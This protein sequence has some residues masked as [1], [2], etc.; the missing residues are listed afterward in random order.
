MPASA[1]EASGR[2]VLDTGIGVSLVTESLATA[3]GASSLGRSYSGRRMSGQEV[4]VPLVEL[5]ELR[6]GPVR[7]VGLVAGVLDLEGLGDLDGFLSLEFFR[8]APFTVDYA[9]SAV[10]V[11]TPESLEARASAGTAVALELVDEGCSLDAFTAL[12]L[13][14]GREISVEVDM[15]SDSLILD[16]SLAEP[17]GIDLAAEDVRRVEGVDETGNAY[18]RSFTRL[19]GAIHPAGAPELAQAEPEVMFQRIIHDGLVGSAF[20][21]R[22]A[23]TYDVAG[24]RMILAVVN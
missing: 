1:G 24:S 22:F 16:A 20:L 17:L 8:H 2:F 21:R 19:A 13:P 12:E 3:S 18:V 11:E 7:R 23:V 14:N 9:N 6:F 4:A 5:P 10:V 15:G